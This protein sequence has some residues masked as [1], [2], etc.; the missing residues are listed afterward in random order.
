MPKKNGVV[1]TY[2]FSTDTIDKLEK[3]CRL[4]RRTQTNCIEKLIDDKFY[5]V[6]ALI[7]DTLGLGEQNA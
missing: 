1:K 2:S 6:K 7:D 3:L 5:E 4:T